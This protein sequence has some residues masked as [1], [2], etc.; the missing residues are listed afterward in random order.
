MA[1]PEPQTR[2]NHARYVPYY[3]FL[4]ASILIVNLGWSLYILTKHPAV[5]AA[6]QALTALALGFVLYYARAFALK[7]QDRV[8]RLEERLRLTRLLPADL[9]PQIEALTSG[10]LA[11]LRFASDAELPGLA[12]RVMDEGIRKRD[13]IKDLIREWRPDHMRA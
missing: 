10:Q 9:Q 7:V 8:I 4:T 11:A 1:S 2:E 5:A 3:H 12:R 13:A 6:V